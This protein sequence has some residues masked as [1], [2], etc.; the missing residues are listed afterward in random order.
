M[1][2]Y[3]R[4]EIMLRRE[5]IKPGSTRAWGRAE[6]GV[7]RYQTSVGDDAQAWARQMADQMIATFDASVFAPPSTKPGSDA[8]KNPTDEIDSFCRE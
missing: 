8:P 3:V 6:A 5:A 7:A 2:A 1:Y 4:Q